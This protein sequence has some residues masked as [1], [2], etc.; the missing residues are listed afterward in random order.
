MRVSRIDRRCNQCHS[1]DQPDHM[2]VGHP[3]EQDDQC[4]RQ[5]KRQ[6]D[7]KCVRFH[8]PI[9]LPCEYR[10]A[11][12]EQAHPVVVMPEDDLL[13]KPQFPFHIEHLDTAVCC[14]DLDGFI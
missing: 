4:R 10:S 11:D 5:E 1:Q 13:A 6:D 14:V 2:V 12:D 3:G 9:P 8:R 7:F